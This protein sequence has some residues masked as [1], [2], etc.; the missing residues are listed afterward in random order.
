M[1]AFVERLER[2]SVAVVNIYVD[3]YQLIYQ[4]MSAGSKMLSRMQVR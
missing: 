1:T 3:I 4:L 2:L